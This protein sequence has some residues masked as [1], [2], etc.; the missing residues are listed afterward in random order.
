MRKCSVSFSRRMFISVP[1]RGFSGGLGGCVSVT[2]PSFRGSFIPPAAECSFPFPSAISLLLWPHIRPCKLPAS[3]I[4]EFASFTNAAILELSTS[5]S[6]PVR[7][8]SFRQRGAPL[9]TEILLAESRLGP[10][11]E[12]EEEEDETAHISTASLTSVSLGHGDGVIRRRGRALRISWWIFLHW[13]SRRTPALVTMLLKRTGSPLC[14][15]AL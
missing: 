2:L 7:L 9:P 5:H 13:V 8:S 15:L 4:R 1:D 10:E 14:E 3:Y 6:A 12:E 11:V